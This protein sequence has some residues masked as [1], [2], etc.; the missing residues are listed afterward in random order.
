MPVTRFRLIHKG[1]KLDVDLRSLRSILPESMTVDTL[2]DG[3][4][5]AITTPQEEDKTAQYLIDRELDR[6]FFLTCVRLNAQMLTKS[7]TADLRLSWAIHGAIPAGT[8]PQKWNYILPIQL[9]LW[10]LAA[11]AEDPMTKIMLLFQ[12]IEL[13]FPESSDYPEYKDASLPP[14]PRTECKLVRHLVAHAGEPDKPQLKLYCDYLG[15][16]YLM[17]DRTDSAHSELIYGKVS[18]VESVAKS[19]LQNA[20]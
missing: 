1:E 18:L 19:L 2:D 17:L 4:Y 8:G 5:I 15:I 11:A 12:I 20:L 3:T 13:S 16:P 14:N 10:A 9:R 6:L 7:V